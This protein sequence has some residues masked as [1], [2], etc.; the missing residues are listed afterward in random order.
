MNLRHLCDEVLVG[1]SGRLI[2]TFSGKKTA[3]FQLYTL[4][5]DYTNCFMSRRYS[6]VLR[7]IID[8][9]IRQPKSD[10]DVVLSS[11]PHPKRSGDNQHVT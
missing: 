10:Q 7:K 4:T 8:A 3:S 1:K 11:E 9:E 5:F 6:Y 2:A